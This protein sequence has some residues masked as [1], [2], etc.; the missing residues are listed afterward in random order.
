M[1]F[2]FS[3]FHLDTHS[4]IV[5]CNTGFEHESTLLFVHQFTSLLNIPITWLEYAGSQEPFKIVSYETC[6]KKGEPFKIL[7]EYRKML[8]NRVARF[9]TQDLKIRC[10]KKYLVSKG[11]DRYESYLGIRYDEQARW[12]RLINAPIKDIFSYNMPLYDMGITQKDVIDFWNDAP[13]NLK[14]DSSLGNCT[15]CFLKGKGNLLKAMKLP[16]N[17][18]NEFNNLEKSFNAT[19]SNRYSLEDLHTLG[20]KQQSLFK[21]DFQDIQCSCTD[22]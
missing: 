14:I 8:P 11:I 18:F 15:M 17:H 21:Y 2:L 6:S 3:L 12:A 16:N 22:D 20:N 10:V 4:E 1:T 13:F 9:C 7:C 19:F 5:F